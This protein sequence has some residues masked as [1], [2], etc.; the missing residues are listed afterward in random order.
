MLGD[1]SNPSAGVRPLRV[2]AKAFKGRTLGVGPSTLPKG[3]R[4][5]ERLRR[6]GRK[7]QGRGSAAVGW[8]VCTVEALGS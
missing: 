8:A 1:L 4:A 6:A 7:K 2:R 3:Q 5:L